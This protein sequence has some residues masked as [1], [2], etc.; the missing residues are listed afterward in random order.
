MARGPCAP[1]AGEQEGRTTLWDEGWE[2]VIDVSR[3]IESFARHLT[4]W[5]HRWRE[6]GVR[7]VADAWLA[8][9]AGYR[10]SVALALPGANYAGIL[11]GLDDAGGLV[12][13]AETTTTI[14]LTVV[15]DGPSWAL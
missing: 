13:T 11:T 12:L 2:D 1:E 9:A 7:P 14:P 8:R 5:L 10:Q 4:T 15:L 3:L 6:D